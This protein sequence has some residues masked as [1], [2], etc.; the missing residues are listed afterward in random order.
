MTTKEAIH[1]IVDALDEDAAR[2][3]LVY[4]ENV[5]DGGSLA[6]DDG[7]RNHDEFL[8]DEAE[9]QHEIDELMADAAPEF[10]LDDPLWSLVGIGST[11]D[12]TNIAKN[13]D[14]YL[15]DAFDVQ[16]P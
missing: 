6:D 9:D 10:T 1:Q 16:R 3:L 14:E 2:A 5:A 13:K 7:A 15:A 8:S 12:A 11:A 4:L